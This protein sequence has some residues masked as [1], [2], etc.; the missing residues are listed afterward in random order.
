[1]IFDGSRMSFHPVRPNHVS[2][3]LEELAVKAGEKQDH[4]QFG[5][6][7]RSPCLLRL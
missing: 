2:V 1:M 4:D 7:G 3:P 5:G 6:N